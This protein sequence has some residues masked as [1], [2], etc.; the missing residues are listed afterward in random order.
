M[1]RDRCHVLVL[2]S[3]PG[4]YVTAIRSA[5]LGLDTLVVE[6]AH[7]GGTCLNVGCIPSKAIIHAANEFFNAT[8][9]TEEN[10]IGISSGPPVINWLKTRSW[11]DG[12]VKRLN[13]GVGG[14]LKRAG[15]R[16]LNGRGRMLDGKTCL[17]ETTKGKVEVTAAHIVIATGSESVELSGLPFSERVLTSTDALAL[18]EI[19]ETLAVI[20]GGYIGLELGI[21]F[22]KLGSDVTV[23]E[24]TDKLLPQ[25]DQELTAPVRSR[26]DALGITTILN[27]RALST[28][29]AGN[30]IYQDG[31]GVEGRMTV[32]KILVTVGRKPNTQD[33]GLEQ[34]VIDMD[35][36]FI[37]IDEQCR[38]SMKNVWAIGDVTGEPM[39]A[40]RAM[41]QGEIV[42]E[43]IAGKN[44]SFDKV[45]IPAVCFTDPE[46]VT[47]GLSPQAATEIGYDTKIGKFPLKASGRAMTMEATD[48]F[49]RIVARA[50]NDLVLGIQAVGQHVAELSASFSLALEM[51]ATLSDLAGTIHAHPT[52]S[53]GVQEA[54]HSA[55]GYPLHI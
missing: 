16:V 31:E 10:A 44:R 38:T 42:A 47:A 23:I 9:F 45:C 26:I 33:I 39:L 34:L 4:G 5:Q 28:N 22:R 54:A 35:G 18:D 7:L 24:A 49:V 36:A 19:P 55:L 25:Y 12:L 51:G 14:L 43:L 2:G 50:D 46:I 3:G 30:L 15:A 52:L 11:K 32:D 29:D 20:G 53:E 21:A 17:V 8:R 6:S 48:G 37:S 27:G 1:Q 13:T 40:H 41:A